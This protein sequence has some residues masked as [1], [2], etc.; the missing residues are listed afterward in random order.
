MNEGPDENLAILLGL[1]IFL[2]ARQNFMTTNNVQLDIFKD[3]CGQASD[4]VQLELGEI[5]RDPE[6]GDAVWTLEPTYDRIRKLLAVT[7][8]EEA[9]G[10]NRDLFSRCV[11]IAAR[12]GVSVT[13]QSPFKTYYAALLRSSGGRGSEKHTL[14]I[15]QVARALGSEEGTLDRFMDK[16]IEDMV[17]LSD[18]DGHKRFFSQTTLVRNQSRCNFPVDCS[19]QSFL[20]PEC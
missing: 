7:E 8:A 5:V 11:A 18:L 1:Q 12:N 4:P 3:L 15:Q 14:L 16:D 17:C 20:R 13:T 6:A 9:A 2:C 19:Y 10:I